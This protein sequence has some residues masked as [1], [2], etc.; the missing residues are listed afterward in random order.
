MGVAGGTVWST[1]PPAVVSAD[2]PV[3]N[4]FQTLTRTK[5]M[6]KNEQAEVAANFDDIMGNE[7]IVVGRTFFGL[8]KLIGVGCL[9][10]IVL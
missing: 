9:I 7:G 10:A 3:T 2:V 1:V 8:L 4:V 6:T 5:Q